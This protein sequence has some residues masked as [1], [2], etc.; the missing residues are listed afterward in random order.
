MIVQ[1]MVF[2]NLGADSGTGVA[3]S[4]NPS[5]GDPQPYGDFLPD[6]QGED[7]VAGVRASLPLGDMRLALPD[8]HA[9][10]LV[11]LKR[12]STRAKRPCSNQAPG[13]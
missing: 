13:W 7:V 2:G 12:I 6:A 10:L 9:R 3:F 1:A 5:T 8:A 11:V 4:R